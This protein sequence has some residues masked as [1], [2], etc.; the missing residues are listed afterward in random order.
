MSAPSEMGDAAASG[1]NPKVSLALKAESSDDKIK[2][3]RVSLNVIE[4]KSQSARASMSANRRKS[5]MHIQQTIEAYKER[6]AS[7][8]GETEEGHFY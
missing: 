2:A 6:Q 7:M 1:E 4:T 5:T 8:L 3:K